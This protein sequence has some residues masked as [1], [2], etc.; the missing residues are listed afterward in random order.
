MGKLD[1]KTAIVTGASRGI[2][3]AIAELFA[4][5]GA[6]VACVARTV[7][8]GDSRAPGALTTTLDGIRAAGGEAR[9]VV[10]N[11]GEEE[12]CLRLVE[13]T[14]AAYGPIDILVNNAV[15]NFAH[16]GLRVPFEALADRLCGEH[17]RAVHPRARDD[18]GHAGAGRRRDRE[19][20]LGC[21]DRARPRPLR[22]DRL[23]R[24][25]RPLRLDEGGAGA[26]HA[27]P[28]GGAVG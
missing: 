3:K 12:E 16:P 22:V 21:R 5:E 11:I 10:A 8:E 9:M 27:G 13:E 6:N 23:G 28:R 20:L 17:P 15:T 14:R 7:N 25:G 19:H 24:H 18:S 4:A 26:L 1:G 2:G